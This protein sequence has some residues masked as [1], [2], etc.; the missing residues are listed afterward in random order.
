MLE[1]LHREQ[2]PLTQVVYWGA[3]RDEDRKHTQ[4]K[5]HDLRVLQAPG[6]GESRPEDV[7]GIE[8][9]G[10]KRDEEEDDVRM[11][12]PVEPL[13]AT[14]VFEEGHRKIVSG[15]VKRRLARI[16]KEEMRG[17]SRWPFMTQPHFPLPISHSRVRPA[18]RRE[19][20]GRRRKSTAP[21]G[22]QA[23]T[24]SRTAGRRTSSA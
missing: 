17:G 18:C 1:H 5:E 14:D 12:V 3:G 15:R 20:P 16:E 2:V 9:G 13:D 22:R 19:W 8:M 21:T 11:E 4:R 24:W 6:V 10:D 23:Q 7:D